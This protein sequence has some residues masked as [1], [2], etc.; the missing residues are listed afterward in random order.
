MS[1]NKIIN[2]ENLT[3][4]D[5]EI[6]GY[7]GNIGTND[8]IPVATTS[9]DGL[10]SSSDKTKLDGIET[11]ANNYSLPTASSSTLGGVK[12][13]SS[14]TSNSGYTACPI[15][16]GVPYYK[17]TDTDTKNT[18]GSTNTSSKIFLIGATSQASNPQTYS[19][20]TVYVGTDGHL[21]SNDIQTVNLSGSQALTNKTYNG[22]TLGAA[23]AKGVDTEATSGSA[24]LITSGAMYTAL[25]DKASSNHSHNYAGSSS[26]GGT[27]NSA[28]KLETARTIN[29]V[30]FNGTSDIIIPRSDKRIWKCAGTE[31][32]AG[33]VKICQIAITAAYANLPMKITLS[34]RDISQYDLHFALASSS[35]TDPNVIAAFV[36]CEAKSYKTPEAYYVKADTGVYDIYVKKTQAY[37]HIYV[38]DFVKADA[39]EGASYTVTWTNVMAISLPSGAV[40]FG[41]T[42]DAA[43]T[44]ASGLMS[45]T[46]KTKLDNITDGA[47]SVSF[48]QSLTS[49][50][51]VGTI[52]ING[53]TYDIYAPTNTD[54]KVSCSS[55]DP[56][57]TTTYYPLLMTGAGTSQG[58]YN[59]DVNFSMKAGT[60][61][62]EGYVT[63]RLGNGTNSGTAGNRFGQLNLYP[64]SGSYYGVIRQA[65]TTGSQTSTRIHYLPDISGTLLSTGTVGKV[66]V[67]TTGTSVSSATVT[68]L[69]TNW[70]LLLLMVCGS[71]GGW[72]QFIIPTALH[73]STGTSAQ[74]AGIDMS[75]SSDL[76]AFWVQRTSDNVISWWESQTSGSETYTDAILVG[77]V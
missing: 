50:T 23:C 47:D 73:G 65:N 15:I 35:G 41:N 16:S 27:A 77:L 1:E 40:Q 28:A 44:S 11:G 9:A 60:T 36:A 20:D 61:S 42:L 7:I 32:T 19:H 72:R 59:A 17:D 26:A 48:S 66:L 8:S 67:N 43:T 4:Y 46:D 45:A 63:L 76:P 13:T 2:L 24:N 29:G 75:T 37:D 74:Y 55:A 34:Q 10:M 52:T 69:W 58:Y 5:N 62:S 38:H 54:T 6:K 31:G 14:V 64:Q 30:N 12:T 18:A 53:T 51:K 22:Y 56:S 33:Y 70:K 68:G 3:Q 57:S 21:Y 71:K 39:D 25:K 49:G